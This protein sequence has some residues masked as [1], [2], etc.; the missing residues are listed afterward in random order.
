VLCA[1]TEAMPRFAH[2]AH[3]E[4]PFGAT[5]GRET[6]MTAATVVVLNTAWPEAA[7]PTLTEIVL[8]GGA[9]NGQ[10]RGF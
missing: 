4:R 1:I 2:Q 8:V 6:G 9:L 3:A 10:R 7:H 5:S